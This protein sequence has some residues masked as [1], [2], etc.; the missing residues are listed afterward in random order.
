MNCPLASSIPLRKALPYPLETACTTRAPWS[1]AISV[2]PSVEPLSDTTTS[3]EM[4]NLR[5][6]AKALSMQNAIDFASLRH[7]ITTEIS[8][9]SAVNPGA[10]TVESAEIS[11]T[12]ALESEFMLNR[13]KI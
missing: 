8:I 4:H 1:S 7:G 2:E 10:T 11:S 3:P 12:A 5:K 6:A 13:I 9:A